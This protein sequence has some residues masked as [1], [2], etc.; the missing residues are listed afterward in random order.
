MTSAYRNALLLS[1][2][3][4]AG[5]GLGRFAY[6][7]LLPAMQADLGWSYAA[8]G[9]INAANA[10]GYLGGAMLAP[11]LA[12]RVGAARAFAAGLAMLLPALAAVALTRDVAALAAL[13]LLA[14]ASGGVVF[15]CGGLLAVGLSLRA[16]SGG[17][18]LGTFYAGTGLGM[19]LS[20]LAVAPLLGIAGATHWPQG[21]L[22]LAGL[23]A[24]CAALALLPLRDGLGASVRQA[25][26]RGPTPLRFWRILAGYLLFGLGSIGYMTFIYGHLAESAGG[27][28]QAMLF[29]CALGLAAVAAPSIWRRLIGGASPERSFALLVATNALGSVLPFLMPGALG[30]WLSAFLFGSTFF[31]TVAATSA[32]ASALP[33]AFDRGRAIRAFTIAFALGQFAGPV[34]LGWTADLTGRLDA[35]LM[36]ASLV[37]LAGALLGV[38]ER[39]PDA[40]DGA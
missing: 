34:V 24:L 32:F 40:I 38:L 39:R 4:A 17:L 28:R 19:I 14:G 2:G 37:V 23:S 30:L 5:I 25:G 26:S 8:A 9:W 16:G 15:V 35:P 36:F 11:A 13:R 12:Q 31:S 27:W 33:Q 29:W 20:A 18:V 10:A 6:A 7:L 21:W 22:I 3:P 1:L